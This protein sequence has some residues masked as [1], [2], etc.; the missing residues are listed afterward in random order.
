MR[1]NSEIKGRQAHETSSSLLYSMMSYVSRE[2]KM[3]IILPGQNR[4]SKTENENR[5]ER[6]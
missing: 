4:M 5:F 3:E 1:K 2:M 6:C